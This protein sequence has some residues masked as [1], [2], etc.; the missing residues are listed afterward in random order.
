MYLSF[1][2]L[3]HWGLV[4]GT[5]GPKSNVSEALEPLLKYAK[6]NGMTVLSMKV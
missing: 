1:G 2:G 3:P 5:D 6:I 4:S